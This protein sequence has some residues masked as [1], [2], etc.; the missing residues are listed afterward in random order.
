MGIFLKDSV[1]PRSYQLA[2]ADSAL[3][4][5]NTLV[6]L[7]T[8]I[9]KTLI[10]FLVI[11]GCIGKGR[12]VFLAPTKPLVAQHCRSFLESTSVEEKDVALI[13]GE[14][15]P[16]KRKELWERKA[17][18]STPQTLKNDLIAGRA[19]P[20]FSLC[21]VDEAHRSVG[22]Y[23]YT[24]VSEKCAQA[25]AKIL[26]LTAS[27]GGSRKRIDEI[28]AA[29]GI[30]NIE[31]RTSEDA[32]VLQYIKKLDASSITV[33][34]G[35]EFSKARLLLAEMLAD[36]SESLSAYGFPVP[37]RSKKA[38]VDLRLKIMRLPE[39][40]RYTALS[41]YST[42][43][44]LAHMLELIETQGPATFFSYI[45]KMKA[46]PDTK[47][48]H[49]I[50]SDR[51]FIEALEACK[52]AAEH[53]KMI[54]LIEVLKT[55]KGEKVLV[56]AQYRDTVQ[57]IVNAI[58][59]AGFTS[60]RFVGKKEGVSSE[61][62]R[63]T[64]E[65]FSRGEFEVMAATSIGEEGLDIPSVDTVI[66]FEPIPSEIRS[67]QRRGRAGRLK[68]GSV[69]VLITEGTRDEA[70][71]HSARKKEE[72]MRRIVRKMQGG[73]SRSNEFASARRK[74]TDEKGKTS[75]KRT[76]AAPEAKKRGTHQGKLTDF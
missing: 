75:A 11:G 2:I 56:F 17:C 60:E 35:K 22:N 55:K 54:K 34:L 46:R 33:P 24:Y 53:P 72:N 45:E 66:F 29:L 65:R 27:P 61:E 74:Q 40:S 25:G 31:I 71:F 52:G 10:A 44:N 68:A 64:I 57:A 47:A 20:D 15:S 21:V 26:G 19:K 51:R 50:F 13:T 23:A 37:T 73:F 3:S 38:L 70:Y 69:V 4:K 39:R 28:V 8:G 30:N 1:V 5:G 9:G 49:R 42:V 32:D 18:F 67:I 7:P 59:Q 12:T 41:F 43:F 76:A 62:Q 14:I 36:Y 63:K 58:R 16:K 6:V 48:R